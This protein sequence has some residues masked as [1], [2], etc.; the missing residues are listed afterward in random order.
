M[1]AGRVLHYAILVGSVVVSVFGVLVMAGIFVP[2]NVPG[3][4][5]IILGVIIALYGVYRFVVAF[6]RQRNRR[7]L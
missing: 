7:A 2:R 1:N 4:Y 5:R 3:D 6:F